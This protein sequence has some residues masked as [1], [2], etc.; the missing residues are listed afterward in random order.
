MQ[1]SQFSY[2]SV[3][4]I[5]ERYQGHSA[6]NEQWIWHETKATVVPIEVSRQSRLRNGIPRKDVNRQLLSLLIGPCRQFE[7]PIL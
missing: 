2:M 1:T 6:E 7:E 3:S 4:Q 5:M